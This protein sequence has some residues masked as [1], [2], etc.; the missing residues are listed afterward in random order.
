MRTQPI[1][2]YI[3]HYCDLSVL[4][5]KHLRSGYRKN[6]PAP[7][8]HS[9]LKI[10]PFFCLCPLSNNYSLTTGK[11]LLPLTTR[12][13]IAMDY[14]SHGRFCLGSQEA[15]S[16]ICYTCMNHSYFSFLPSSFP[17]HLFIFPQLQV[18]LLSVLFKNDPYAFMTLVVTLYKSCF[19][20]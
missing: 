18:S 10:G 5:Q 15:Q 1:L 7:Y 14:V 20:K 17:L 6:I 19:W 11:S 12:L 16:E 4:I 8:M 2:H 3:L 13:L 9:L